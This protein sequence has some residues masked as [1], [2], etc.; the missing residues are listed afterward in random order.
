MTKFEK[1]T[2][3]RLPFD[4]RSTDPSKNYGIDNLGVWFVLKGPKGAIQFIVSFPIYLPHVT[5]EKGG[6]LP[7]NISGTD[8]GHHAKAPQYD[9]QT[10][11][12]CDYFGECYYD[13]SSLRAQEWADQIFSITGEQPEKEIWRRLEQEY[14]YLF[15]EE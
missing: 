7:G 12:K 2:N 8:V 6:L 14:F 3:V 1:I 15:G 10:S 9:G 11:M 13:G 4:C 5:R